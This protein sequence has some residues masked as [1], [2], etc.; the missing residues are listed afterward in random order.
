MAKKAVKAPVTG[1][2][3]KYNSAG[4]KRSTADLKGSEKGNI[5]RTIRGAVSLINTTTA[6]KKEAKKLA[7]RVNSAVKPNGKIDNLDTSSDVYKGLLS[8]CKSSINGIK[9][10]D[11]SAA[12]SLLAY[13]QEH[14]VGTGGGGKRGFNP[15]ALSD[16]SF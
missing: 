15:A 6:D 1:E 9:N 12:K 5:I 8:A 7:G 11:V 2:T 13:L 10:S 3:K 4:K 14:L 16:I